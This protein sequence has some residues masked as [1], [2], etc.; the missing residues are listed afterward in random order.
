MA[1]CDSYR[2][3]YM[4][5]EVSSMKICPSSSPGVLWNHHVLLCYIK[6]WGLFFWSA[7]YDE[8]T[9]HFPLFFLFFFCLLKERSVLARFLHEHPLRQ[10]SRGKHRHREFRVLHEMFSGNLTEIFLCLGYTLH[11]A[12][13]ES[14]LSYL[15]CLFFSVSMKRSASIWPSISSSHY[16]AG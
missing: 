2:C 13:G 1:R 15:I 16:H 6:A 11:L 5:S 12:S 4:Y 3:C 9:V 10:Y 7:V 14:S 8:I